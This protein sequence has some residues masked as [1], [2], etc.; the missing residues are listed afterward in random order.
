VAIGVVRPTPVSGLAFTGSGVS[1]WPVIAGVI[2]LAM[3]AVLHLLTQRAGAHE[4]P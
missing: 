3:G 2:L 4:H 1:W